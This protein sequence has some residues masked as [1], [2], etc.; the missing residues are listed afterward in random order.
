M[1]ISGTNYRDE[2]SC[3]PHG[4]TINA[5]I[6]RRAARETFASIAKSHATAGLELSW[7]AF[8]P[9][10]VLASTVGRLGAAPRCGAGRAIAGR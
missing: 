10:A 6:R 5:A 7:A 3:S 2:N 4:R 9:G 1:R 8:A